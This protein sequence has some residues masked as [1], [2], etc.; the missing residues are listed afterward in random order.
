[1]ATFS[2]TWNAAFEA[3]VAD[4]DY[5]LELGICI[6]DFKKAV[7]ERFGI[8]HSIAGDANDGMHKV[9]RLME[10]GANPTC[11][12]DVGFLFTKDVS[13]ITELFYQG[14]DVGSGTCVGPVQLTNNGKIGNPMRCGAYSTSSTPLTS[15][16]L[17]E[18]ILHATYYD[19][20]TRFL[21][22]RI[23]VDEAG[24]YGIMGQ[25]SVSNANSSM[26]IALFAGNTEIPESIGIDNQATGATDVYTAM[27]LANLSASD[28]INIRCQ[29][30]NTGKSGSAKLA[31]IRLH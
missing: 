4:N 23:K 3:Y 2:L 16:S 31:V 26:R 13:G 12:A 6:R 24:I 25:V 20:H 15:G 21:S 27:A 11:I 22:N 1:M 10:Q 7:R 9:V 18:V 8:D 17:T 14:Y 5:A 29:V 19:S 28:E 30:D